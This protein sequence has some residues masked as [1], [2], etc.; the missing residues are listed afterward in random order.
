MLIVIL[1]RCG[2][3]YVRSAMVSAMV[4]KASTPSNAVQSR[5]VGVLVS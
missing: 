2:L 4:S 1:A 3:K 5:S